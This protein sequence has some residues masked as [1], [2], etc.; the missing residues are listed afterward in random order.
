MQAAHDAGQVPLVVR[1]VFHRRVGIRDAGI[2]KDVKVDA[3][4]TDDPEEVP[5]QRAEPGERIVLLA[6]CKVEQRFGTAEQD[7]EQAFQGGSPFLQVS[8]VT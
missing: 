1:H 7:A 3:R 6:E 8:L 5:A 2:E 4:S